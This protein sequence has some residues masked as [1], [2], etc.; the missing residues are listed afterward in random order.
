MKKSYMKKIGRKIRIA[1]VAPPFGQ[2]GGPEVVCRHLTNALV[3]RG[4]AV[5]LF[6]PGDWKTKAKLVPTLPKSLWQM[7]DFKKQ[8]NIFRKNLIFSSQ[9]EV[10]KHQ[11]DFDIIHLHSQRNAATVAP[12]ANKPCVLTLHNVV[13][14][15]EFRQIRDAGI[16]PVAISHGR[17]VK[18]QVAAVIENGINLKE[19]EFSQK[20]GKYL[21]CVGRIIEGK[22]VD[23]AIDLARKSREKIVIIG[24]TGNSAERQKY[25]AKKIKPHLGKT[26]I[27]KE[28]MPQKALFKYLR[29]AKALLFPI[30]GKLSL[31]P[32]IVM[33]ALASGTPTI[34]T[35]IQKLPGH[36]K[37]DR[38]ACLSD[39]SSD[40][41]QAIKTIDRF[42]RMACRR[43][44]EKYFSS[45][46]MTEKYLELYNKIVRE[47]KRKQ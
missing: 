27:F 7:S 10:I 29:E 12:L 1:M 45:D 28:Q 31:F 42:D 33:E 18:L 37:N 38:V 20:P 19:I 11:S 25:F 43:Y 21:L 46:V 41:L 35:S 36:M 24:R 13:K 39:K 15:M 26:I 5:T 8:T 47:D 4:V 23:L 44:A 3:D 2:E 17:K 30:R 40:W 34:G 9:L 32:L 22:G 16:F 6:A 14:E